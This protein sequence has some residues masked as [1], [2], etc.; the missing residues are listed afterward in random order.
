[1]TILST[2]STACHGSDEQAQTWRTAALAVP[3]RSP[4]GGRVA[5]R[6][7]GCGLVHRGHLG[8]HPH[9]RRIVRGPRRGYDVDATAQVPVAR[10]L[11]DDARRGALH[12]QRGRQPA[13]VGELAA[14]GHDGLRVALRGEQPHD[15]ALAVH[16]G[17]FGGRQATRA[18]SYTA[19]G[20][21]DS[22]DPAPMAAPG[23]GRRRH[24]GAAQVGE[25]RDYIDVAAAPSNTPWHNCSTWPTAKTLALTP[26]TSLT[27]VAILID[28]TTDDSPTTASRQT[29]P[30]RYGGA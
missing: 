7:D 8:H 13:I 2:A 17:Q 4:R 24:A 16:S 27:S 20:K 23:S 1:L 26:R 3:G 11:T 25:V 18:A 22:V 5:D 12:E 9:D 15:R 21:L 6:E 19:G 30:R 28:S 10:D 14:H 29:K